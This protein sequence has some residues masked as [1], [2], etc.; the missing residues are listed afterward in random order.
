MLYEC[1]DAIK[2]VFGNSLL[3]CCF[4]YAIFFCKKRIGASVKVFL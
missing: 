3:Q 2:P 1:S 4:P